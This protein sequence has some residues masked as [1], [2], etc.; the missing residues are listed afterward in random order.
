M[1]EVGL[2]KFGESA[3]DN[4]ETA[5]QGSHILRDVQDIF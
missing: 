4:L 5:E 3:S 1:F 2:A